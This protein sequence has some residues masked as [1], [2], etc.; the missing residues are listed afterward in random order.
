MARRAIPK[1][2]GEGGCVTLS[3]CEGEDEALKT[4]KNTQDSKQLERSG[5]AG[6]GVTLSP[7]EGGDEALTTL[8]TRKRL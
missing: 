8:V 5:G 7:R 3:P 2:G 6:G 4:L 1:A